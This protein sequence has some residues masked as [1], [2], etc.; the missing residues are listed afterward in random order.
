MNEPGTLH[1]IYDQE[2]DRC[3][4]MRGLLYVTLCHKW[5]VFRIMTE[6]TERKKD[7]MVLHQVRT[8]KKT[9]SSVGASLTS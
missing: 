5:V 2:S 4:T 8:R 1:G 6:V 3:C 9:V 7:S